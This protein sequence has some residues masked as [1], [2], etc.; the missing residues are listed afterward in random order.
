MADEQ[1]DDP[2]TAQ[3]A[4]PPRDSEARRA[5]A[6]RASQKPQRNHADRAMASIRAA[7]R[8]QREV[9][10]PA[11]RARIMLAEAEVLALLDLAAAVGM[12]PD[13]A[14]A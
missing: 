3:G 1:T 6:Q 9:T 8:G 14:D 7:K 5:K 11:E 2:K 12:S 10:D 13:G 4:K